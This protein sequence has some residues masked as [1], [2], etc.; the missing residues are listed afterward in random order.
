MPNHDGTGPNRGCCKQGEQGEKHNCCNKEQHQHRHGQ[1]GGCCGK[2]K[3]HGHDT[4][5]GECCQK[6]Q[7]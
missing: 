2:G 3:G 1:E 4:Q 5:K 6:Q 7:D